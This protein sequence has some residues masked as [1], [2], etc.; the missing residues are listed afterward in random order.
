M[1]PC[2]V[3]CFVLDRLPTDC[4]PM[5]RQVQRVRRPMF[6]CMTATQ[7]AAVVEPP[8]QI[9]VNPPQ[10]ASFLALPSSSPPARTATPLPLKVQNVVVTTILVQM[11][12]GMALLA[13]TA[14]K[15]VGKQ[16]L[17]YRDVRSVC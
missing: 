4:L 1:R 8:A 12:L 7:E 3:P 2:G 11:S 13:P 14:F 15:V 10:P 16:S 9:A 6:A 17:P 5:W